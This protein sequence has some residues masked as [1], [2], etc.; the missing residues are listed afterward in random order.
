MHRCRL[1]GT[2]L[3]L[4]LLCLVHCG[5]GL[6]R[7][8]CPVGPAGHG[9]DG[10]R[11]AVRLAETKWR[12]H[13]RFG[14]I[15]L[16]YFPPGRRRRGKGSSFLD[17]IFGEVLK[18]NCYQFGQKPDRGKPMDW[19]LDIGANAGMASIMLAKLYPKATILAFEANPTTYEYL[20][21]NLEANNV[22]NVVPHNCAVADHN[23]GVQILGRY[24]TTNA[25]VPDR[26]ER[27]ERVRTLTA[28]DS[29]SRWVG[30]VTVPDI[31]SHFN[32][33]KVALLK[34]DCEYCEYAA[35]P[36]ISPSQYGRLAGE[37]HPLPA[38]QQADHRVVQAMFCEQKGLPYGYGVEGCPKR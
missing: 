20:L 17:H 10:S 16:S 9:R 14:K 22:T 34:I 2:T 21:M 15:T 8:D 32:L 1:P 38:D 11:P 24:T 18:R 13:P 26:R 33:T 37:L 19:M 28:F 7:L 5:R 29:D 3:L 6:G 30:S 35:L 31:Y 12:V 27:N 23:R 25:Q 36:Q 4:I